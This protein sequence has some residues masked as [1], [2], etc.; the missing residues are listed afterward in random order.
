MINPGE[1]QNFSVKLW[2][3]PRRVSASGVAS[4]YLQVILSG[5]HKEFLLKLKWTVN[6]IDLVQGILLPRT[7]EDLD[8]S[9]YNMLITDQRT[10]LNE[11][12]K[13]YRLRKAHL[14]LETLSRELKTFSTKENFIAYSLAENK[15]RYARKEIEQKTF[16]N[17]NA[18]MVQVK[19]FQADV[20]IS[21][22]NDKW[23]KKFKFYLEAKNY[24]PGTVWARVKN[25][26]TML[27]LADTEPMLYVN[28]DAFKFS[29]P[30]PKDET[31]FLDQEELR[32]LMLLYD[33]MYL[34][35][36]EYQVLSAFLFSCFTGIRISDIY[37][38][39]HSWEISEDFIRFL[40]HKNRKAGKYITI[41]VIPAAKRFIQ[42]IIGNYFKLPSQPEYNRTLKDLARKAE[43]NKRLTSH[44]GRHTFGYLY[45]TTVGNIYALKENL[46]HSKIET[47]DRY[48]HLDQNYKLQAAKKL[49]EAFSD[50]RIL[51][52]VS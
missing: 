45:M 37:R 35:G 12:F 9:D 36:I 22:I 15:K 48:A 31:T 52:V 6:H 19:N 5:K 34:T 21:E 18:T 3:N 43:I 8:V 2:Y 25:V 44:V 39:H 1:M 47:T 16:Q 40:P 14:D 32:R 11:I 17:H 51:K 30:K 26:V 7:K 23:L 20:L 33:P 10:K 4:L 27:H 41:P 24:K 38:A 49:Q 29:L 28:P 13:T 42:T 50:M 46:G